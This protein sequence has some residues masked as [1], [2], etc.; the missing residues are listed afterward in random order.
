MPYFSFSLLFYSEK[1]DLDMSSTKQ[2]IGSI[3]AGLKTETMYT[4]M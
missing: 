4:L 2:K 3:Y 1:N